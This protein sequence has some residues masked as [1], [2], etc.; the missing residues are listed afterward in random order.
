MI[1]LD[2]N[3]H[4]SPLSP[5][6]KQK[7]ILPTSHPDQHNILSWSGLSHDEQSF[8]HQE[9]YLSDSATSVHP[10]LTSPVDIDKPASRPG[11]ITP[12][13]ATDPVSHTSGPS[14]P[15]SPADGNS[16]SPTRDRSSSLSPVPDSNSPHA[17]GRSSPPPA[18][19]VEASIE[20]ARPEEEE[21]DEEPQIEKSSRQSTPL[22]ELSPPPPDLEEALEA[23]EARAAEP[24]VKANEIEAKAEAEEESKQEMIGGEAVDSTEGKGETSG[25]FGAES[26]SPSLATP[27]SQQSDVGEALASQ[28]SLDRGNNPGPFSSNPM[29]LTPSSSLPSPSHQAAT[30]PTR[31]PSQPESTSPSSTTHIDAKVVSILELNAELLKCVWDDFHALDRR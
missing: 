31:I 26:A 23:A 11:P 3:L 18:E 20:V 29:S 8:H 2:H 9:N 15:A 17:D 5:P 14:S 21:E 28:S 24:E 1:H 19:E 30:E 25:N 6:S 13:D 12:V 27:P 16:T 22:S 4:P 10:G 7:L